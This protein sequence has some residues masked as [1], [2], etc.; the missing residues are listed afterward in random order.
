MPPW[1]NLV[2]RPP[3]KRIAARLSWFKSGRWRL[4]K[5]IYDYISRKYMLVPNLFSKLRVPNE[6]PEGMQI[7]EKRLKKC[8]TKEQYLYTAY[9]LLSRHHKGTLGEV[10]LSLPTLF[11]RDIN[12]LWEREYM[13][14]TGL[15]YLLRILLIKSRHFREEDIK[16]RISW[17]FGF[18]PHVF[19]SVRTNKG[20]VNVDPWGRAVGIHFG[21][22]TTGRKWLFRLV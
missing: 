4:I 9:V 8:K 11:M 3:R 15:C 6:I 14:C 21:D 2:L 19:L 10:L 12:K 5:F 13:Q 1:D 22:Y 18:F 17:C 16:H 7:I 20:W